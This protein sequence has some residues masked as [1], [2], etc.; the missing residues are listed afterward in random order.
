MHWKS[1]TWNRSLKG[2]RKSEHLGLW[3]EERSDGYI[4]GSVSKRYKMTANKNT[5]VLIASEDLSDNLAWISYIDY[6]Q[7]VSKGRVRVCSSCNDLFKAS[8]PNLE[9]FDI[10]NDMFFKFLI[11]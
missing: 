6:F 2:N 7:K 9:F 11:T 4:L 5:M 10:L 3:H 8:Y 1:T